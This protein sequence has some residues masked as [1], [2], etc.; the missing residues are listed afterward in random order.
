KLDQFRLLHLYAN[1][2][3]GTRPSRG[4]STSIARLREYHTRL[5]D[6]LR[7]NQVPEILAVPPDPRKGAIES[8][9]KFAAAVNVPKAKTPAVVAPATKVDDLAGWQ[10]LADD[11]RQN[12]IVRRLQIHSKLAEIGPIQPDAIVKW[13]YKDVLHADLDD[14]YL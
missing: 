1:G 10:V 8:A 6:A 14:P 3:M 12:E 7:K 11:T 13:L 5:A 4:D 9:V 2:R